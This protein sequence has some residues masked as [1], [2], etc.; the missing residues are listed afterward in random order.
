MLVNAQQVRSRIIQVL[1]QPQLLFF[2]PDIHP[3]NIIK[4]VL[5][6]KFEWLQKYR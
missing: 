3:D 4:F 1:P 2:F 5:G 6:L